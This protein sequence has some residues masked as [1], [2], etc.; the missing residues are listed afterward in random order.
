ME[1]GAC[2][3]SCQIRN[4]VVEGQFLYKNC[5]TLDEA[6]GS[7]MS[8]RRALFM[9]KLENSCQGVFKLTWSQVNSE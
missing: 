8:K 9:C 3:G 4:G 7:Q 1:R 5:G 6:A 2:D